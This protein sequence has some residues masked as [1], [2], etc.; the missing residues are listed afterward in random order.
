[1]FRFDFNCKDKKRV[2][3]ISDRNKSLFI[4]VLNGYKF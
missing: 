1:M 2:N 3:I 4:I